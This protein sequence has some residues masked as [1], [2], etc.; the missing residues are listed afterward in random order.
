LLQSDLGDP[1]LT[2]YL[3]EH[4]LRV[5][6]RPDHLGTFWSPPFFYPAR[7]VLTYSENLMGML[8]IYA[9]L[10]LCCTPVLSYQLLLILL[11]ILDYVAMLFV[12]RR[13]G[14]G[15][16]L[17]ALGG[18]LFAFGTSHYGQLGHIQLF[19][20]FYAP[21]AL[22]ALW[23]LLAAPSLARLAL[24]LLLLYLQLLS[25]IYL[26]WFLLLA[27]GV[28]VPL[29][30]LWDRDGRRRL[31]AFCRAAPVS[32]TLA[33]AVWT[34]AVLLALRPYLAASTELGARP[35]QAVQIFLPRVRSWLGVP[36]RSPYHAWLGLPPTM[37][38]A[39]EHCLF[40][41]LVLIGLGVVSAIHTL[42]LSRQQRRDQALLISSWIAA[43]VLVMASL[44]LPSLGFDG[45]HL[46]RRYPGVSL[47]WYIY[48]WVPGARAIRAVGR[49]S[50]LIEMLVVVAA[51]LGADA[52]IRRSRLRPAVRA[53]LLAAL[54]LAGVAEQRV[55]SPPAADKQP[56][57]A[58]VAAVR[59][60]I[61]HGCRLLYLTV[62]AGGSY[63]FTQLVAM[64]AGLDSNLPVVNGYSGN[65]P[66]GYP[67][68]LRT[69]TVAELKAWS[70]DD[71][72][73]VSEP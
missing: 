30:L 43:L 17:A 42:R 53:A 50:I 73:M 33:V 69:W 67:P 27:L 48:E 5:I 35:W 25:G 58:R 45:M 12:L 22:W 55:A 14:V 34:A 36:P 32:V 63:M 13:L 9:L 24:L 47:W 31:V 7:H 40:P 46:V 44:Q 65:S 1:V 62:P 21:L 56:F 57:L 66:P 4:E 54:L 26:G 15:P 70:G 11:C 60:N 59:A 28:V 2:N 38:G 18:F 72:C 68:Q 49:I 19:P 64:W 51:C 37:S 8:P 71:P 20:A 61:P 39:W 52:V 3:L 29:L 6:E 10:R 16:P 23:R 41:G